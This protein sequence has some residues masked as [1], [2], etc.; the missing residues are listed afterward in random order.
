MHDGLVRKEVSQMTLEVLFREDE[1]VYSY[2]F[3]TVS[4]ITE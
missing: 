1:A 4:S 2:P 3:F